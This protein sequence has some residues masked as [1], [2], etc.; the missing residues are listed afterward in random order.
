M[1]LNTKLITELDL[2]SEEKEWKDTRFK[3][4]DRVQ[5]RFCLSLFK[6]IPPL[7]P[8]FLYKSTW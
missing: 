5:Q 6:I 4:H 2:L 3:Q 8:A 7:Q 1:D